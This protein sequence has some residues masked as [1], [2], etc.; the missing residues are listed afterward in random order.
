MHC[1]ALLGTM[2]ADRFGAADEVIETID[3]ALLD[4]LL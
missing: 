4:R 3:L 1:L 2:P